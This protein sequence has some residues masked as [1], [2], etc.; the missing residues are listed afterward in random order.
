MKNASLTVRTLLVRHGETADNAARLVQ[1]QRGGR[2]SALGRQQAL[3]V[4]ER[5]REAAIV[6]IYA[7]DLARARESAEIVAAALGLPPVVTD[8]RLRE[9]GFGVYEGGPVRQLLRGMVRAGGDFTSFDPEGGEPAQAFRA[10]L[11]S[12]FADLAVWHPGETVLLLTHH[13]VIRMAG[14]LSPEGAGAVGAAGNG[15]I[16]LAE[17]GRAGVLS[18]R[19]FT[20]ASREEESA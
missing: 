2:L 13:G 1:G 18:F 8:A 3:M 16:T 12:F 11:A 9:Q 4:G 15:S 17:I 20:T 5:L 14:R 6:A 19:E 10:R 7:S